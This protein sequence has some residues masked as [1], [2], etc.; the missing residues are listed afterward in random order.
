MKT[1]TL[2]KSFANR[3]R[4]LPR[5]TLATVLI[6]LIVSSIGSYF[7][8]YAVNGKIAVINISI[9]ILTREDRD[10]VL[11][12]V[13]DAARPDVRAVV[14]FIDSEGGVASYAEEIYRDLLSLRATKPIVAS[15]VGLGVSGSY[16]IAVASNYI[17]TESTA[18]VGNVG[19]VGT[20]PE[21]VEPSEARV[22]TGP[23]KLIGISAKD[24][25]FKVQLAFDS[26]ADAVLAQRAEKLKIDKRE[27]SK[28]QIYIGLDAVK[29]GLADEIGSSYDALRKAA[30]LAGLLSYQVVTINKQ[31]GVYLSAFSSRTEVVNDLDRLNPPPTLYYMYLPSLT[32]YSRSYVAPY[33][34]LNSTSH[35]FPSSSTIRG[36]ILV[37]YSHYNRFYR[38]ELNAFLGEVVSR[39][40]KISYAETSDEFKSGLSRATA[41]IVISPTVRFTGSEIDAVKNFMEGGGKVLIMAEVTRIFMSTL[42]MFSAEFGMVFSEGY[43]Y[44]LDEYYGNYRDIIVAN[45]ESAAVM[46]DLKKLVFYTA[47]SIKGN[48]TPLANT[49]PTTIYSDSEKPGTYTVIASANNLLAIGDFTFMTEPYCYVEDNYQLLLNMIEFLTG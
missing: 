17:Y 34:S 25:R 37:D 28:G 15:I 35:A 40:Y 10:Y 4:A 27:L 6:I 49:R 16:Y 23:Y 8:A 14:L 42:N 3:L 39:G 2:F 33:A 45:F 18:F 1:R 26:F 32:K 24:F 44:D 13:N 30:S 48:F 31:L 7:V 46:K 11:N 22:E 38:Y 20:L 5:K 19:V 12:L 41:L 21:R 9:P 47:T 36:T 29:L 43:L